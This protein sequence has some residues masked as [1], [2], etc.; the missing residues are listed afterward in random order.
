MKTEI[1]K[2]GIIGM[3]GTDSTKKFKVLREGSL[4]RLIDRSTAIAL[5]KNKHITEKIYMIFDDSGKYPCETES[6]LY[7]HNQD[8]ALY[9]G[10]VRDIY[11]DIDDLYDLENGL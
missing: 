1:G 7:T 2:E 5:W 9:V 10:D 6:D 11:A 3:I 8:F 4:V